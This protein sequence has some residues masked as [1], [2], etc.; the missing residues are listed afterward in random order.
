MKKVIVW[1]RKDLRIHD[2]PALYYASKEG[3]VIPLFI[4]S[5]DE[6]KELKKGSAS[7]WWLHHSLIVLS[8]KL[9][10]L[11]AKLILQKGNSLEV[12]KKLN[13]ETKADAVY[14]NERYEPSIIKRD[15]TI[16]NE[17]EK[18][19]IELKTYQ[20]HLLYDPYSILNQQNQPYKVFTPFYKQCLKK[21]VTRPTKIPTS[22][23]A[24]DKP[25]RS[26]TIDELELLPNIPWYEKFHK[27]WEPGEEGAIKQWKR[28]IRDGL[29]HYQKKRD[30]PTSDAF[31]KLS[32][33]LSWGN[34]SPKTIWHALEREKIIIGQNI[35]NDQQ[36]IEAF[37]RQLIWREFGYHQLIHF[38]SITHTPLRSMFRSFPWEKNEDY[39]MKWKK[40][41]TGFPLVD[42]GMRELWETGFM[43]NRVRMLTASFLVKHL[44]IP[45]PNGACWFQD[46]LVDFDIAN[47]AMGWQWTTGCGLDAAPYFRIFNPM[48]QGEK[49]D[50]NGDYIRKWVPELAKLP[51]K[52]IHRPWEAPKD[53]LRKA[54]IELGKTY[55]Y[56]L[57]EHKA[58]RERALA[59]YNSL[60]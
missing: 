4:W 21:E 23:L 8:E 7:L 47:N 19:Q 3:I 53:I 49:F 46:T 58:A 12:I 30:I 32:P 50:P 41:K 36:H 26:L 15:Q 31:S 48:T 60:K 27:Y 45:W 2:N 44:L 24:Y 35:L 29:Y 28:F 18:D 25:I 34:I 55:P 13:N 52:Y 38:P 9:Q 56:P 17:L 54:N 1:F 16:I 5:E 59:I 33:F 10:K 42:A 11:G 39:F 14:W 6:E 51:P 22:L 57:V 43:H 20:S 40:G 37:Q